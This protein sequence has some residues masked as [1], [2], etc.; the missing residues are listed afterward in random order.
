[1][2]EKCCYL[3]FSLAP[4][5]GPVRFRQLIK[6]FKTV[7][8][9]WF[10]SFE[11]YKKAGIG[12][13]TFEHFSKFRDTFT[14]QSYLEELKQKEVQFLTIEDK[15]Y[16]ILLKE[17]ED[18][19]LVLFVKGDISCLNI[20]KTIAVVGT[21]KM[22]GYGK[23]V[24]E[25]LVSELVMNGFTIVSGLALGVDGQ[26][27]K[28]AI[29]NKGKTVAVLG[30]GVDS[31]YPRENQFVYN[32]IVNGNGAVLSSFPLSMEPSAGTFPARNR[33]IS[34]LSLGVLVT[35]A[36]EDS[37]SLITAGFAKEQNRP[38]FAVPGPITSKQSDGTAKLLKSGAVLIRNVND[39]LDYFKFD[40]KSIK[41]QFDMEKLNLT[42]EE[43]KIVE[44]LQ[45]EP[46]HINILAKNTGI[47]VPKLNTIVTMLEL[48][49]IIKH[50]STGE[51]K[52]Q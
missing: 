25:K 11:E 16:P 23:E 32:Q 44:Y 14:I 52:I 7:K 29:E 10:G 8:D 40:R 28:T 31:C 3:A 18:I 24:T 20:K 12:E 45:N 47:E 5:I 33:I 21:R 51:V 26:A 2:D 19:P 15:E 36:G 49:G 6:C 37:G 43:K 50:L 30:S 4:G 1:M 27:H 22:T 34:G 13:K 38:V 48:K 9:A 41:N 46:L 39:I 17:I 42:D 35:E